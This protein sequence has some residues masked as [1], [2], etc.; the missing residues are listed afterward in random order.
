MDEEY[1]RPLTEREQL[2]GYLKVLY[3]YREHVERKI[4]RAEHEYKLVLERGK[5]KGK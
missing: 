2:E 1:I 3:A 4:T 5:E